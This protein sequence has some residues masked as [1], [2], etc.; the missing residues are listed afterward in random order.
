MRGGG[1]SSSS[2]SIIDTYV[3]GTSGYRI[4]SDGYC[5]QWGEGNAVKSGDTA[6]LNI[7]FTKTFKDTNYRFDGVTGDTIMSGFSIAL[8][9]YMIHS[10]STTG[11]QLYGGGLNPIYWRASGFLADGQ[12]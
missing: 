9:G 6:V 11:A 1:G 2:I 10:K 12:Y 8:P 7:T 5:E 4:W 3:N